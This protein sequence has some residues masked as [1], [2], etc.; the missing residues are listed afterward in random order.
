MQYSTE[1][2]ALL[3]ARA[4]L[5]WQMDFCFIAAACAC[6]VPA[7]RTRRAW[8]ALVLAI[9][10]SAIASMV[11]DRLLENWWL[12]LEAA[13]ST[14]TDREWLAQHDGGRLMGGLVL[15]MK[16]GLCFFVIIVAAWIGRLWRGRQSQKPQLGTASAA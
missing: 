9:V 6:A 13:V 10:G 5:L 1:F 3:D 2:S 14:P 8:L 7:F 15:L 12:N 4:G 16:A 11:A